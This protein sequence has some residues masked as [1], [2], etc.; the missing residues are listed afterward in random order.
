[1]EPL[2]PYLWKMHFVTC[3]SRANERRKDIKGVHRTIASATPSLY[4]VKP[5]LFALHILEP[6]SE[7]FS[8]GDGKRGDFS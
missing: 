3:R 8:A 6:E 4:E 2:G 1:M 7:V 5:L